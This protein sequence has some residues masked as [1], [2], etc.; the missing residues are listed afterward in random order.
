MVIAM[1]CAAYIEHVLTRLA[2]AIHR[3][4]RMQKWQKPH[5]STA[6]GLPDGLTS[7]WRGCGNATTGGGAT[8]KCGVEIDV[9]TGAITTPDLVN[10]R[11]ADRALPLQQRD[12]PPGSLLLADRGFYHL[13]R[14]RQHDQQGGL[15]ITRLPSNAVVAYPGHGMQPLATFVRALGP[16]ATWD[17]AIS[18]GKEQQVH[19][20]LVVT[21]VTQAV[22]DQRRARIRQHAQHQHWMPSAAAL[23]LAEWNVVFTNAPRLLISATE[24]WALV[25][26]RWQIE[27]LFKLW[28]RHARIDDWRTANPALV[29]CEIYAKVIGLVFQQWLLA[30]SS[31]HDPKRSLFKAAPIVAGMA[32]E[33]ASTQAD[34]TQFLP[35]FL[36]V[37]T[38]LAALIPALG[39]DEQTASATN[40]GSALTGINGIMNHKLDAH[41]EFTVKPFRGWRERTERSQRQCIGMVRNQT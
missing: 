8:L 13:E 39:D 30:A 34:P 9:L 19:G 22:A 26:V 27:L 21:R 15:W 6:I 12:L 36:R 24:V 3:L 37:L 18:V 16:V 4:A 38:R 23:A 10:G 5:D 28:K 1:S 25:R 20:R 31:W 11:A 32:G 40:H 7:T 2:Q 33:L 41:G 35:Q 17:C 14:L 29:L